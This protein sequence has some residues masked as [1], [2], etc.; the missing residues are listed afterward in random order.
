MLGSWIRILLIS[1]EENYNEILYNLLQNQEGIDFKINQVDSVDSAI[2]EIN[3]QDYDLIILDLSAREDCTAAAKE[4]CNASS[5]FP[6][7]VITRSDN[8][9]SLN[10]LK[11]NVHQIIRKDYL[12][13]NMITQ[14][15]LSA[16][17]RKKFENEVQMRDE[18]L[19]AVNNAA[20]IFLTQTDWSSYLKEVLTSL[21]KATKSDRVF[22]FS[23]SVSDEGALV[24]EFQAEWVNEDFQISKTNTVADGLNY[25]EA[26][27]GRWVKIMQKG[28]V[29]H[30]NVE[31]FPAK[32][33]PF[34]VKLGVKSLIYVPIFIDHTWWGF[35]GFNQC[36]T[37]ND[38][39]KVEI[40][41]LQTAAKILGAA[42]SR[43]VT[44]EKLIYLA[45]HDYLTNLPNR[46]L[47]EDRFRQAQ[48]R[49]DRTGKRFAIVS[50]DLDRFKVV[51]DTH[52]H[53][54]GDQVLY[55]VAK[56]LT[57]A[58]RGTDTCARIGG[59]EFAII[60]EEIHDKDD[61]LRIMEKITLTLQEAITL[62]KKE[63]QVSAS[64]GA[65][66]YPAHGKT[67]E[68]L[69]RAADKTLYLIKGSTA[70]YKIFSDDQI[71]WLRE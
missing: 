70:R 55:E 50:I 5:H 57:I 45:T 66:I 21:G 68:E 27:L 9:S 65:S 6:L 41:A 48:A 49:S 58:I 24:G 63:I 60:A 20:E 19:Q 17:D 71:T 38:W 54:I 15:I 32:E 11:S 4:I 56:R 23:N 10:T 53:Q 28:E 62:E 39:L 37:H 22:V 67:M 2:K 18:I 29:I 35:I 44:E 64:M 14:T 61:V 7:I 47:F 69:M 30:G 26:D 12:N 33:Q 46:L 31:D 52:G 8:E 3:S 59:D 42:I 25:V 13:S 1:D 36:T 16:I 51:N 43:Q 40:D 34:L